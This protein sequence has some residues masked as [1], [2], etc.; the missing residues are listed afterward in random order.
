[1]SHPPRRRWW[2]M[3]ALV[4]A[5][6][7]LGFLLL[8]VWSSLSQ[9][10]RVL[11]QDTLDGCLGALLNDGRQWSYDVEDPRFVGPN[12]IEADFRHVG[13]G[14]TDGA[15]KEGTLRCR[16]AAEGELDDPL[17]VSSVEVVAP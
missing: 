13:R 8:G 10:D 17:L 5:N 3:L 14:G 9:H 4:L 6:L 12:T 1:M 15:P 2:A 16:L 7:V 11:D